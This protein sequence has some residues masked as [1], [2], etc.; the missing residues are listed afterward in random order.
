MNR[1]W[2]LNWNIANKASS[3]AYWTPQASRSGRPFLI[4][5]YSVWEDWVLGCFSARD[6]SMRSKQD[7]ETY[8]RLPT[9]AQ[10]SLME[11]GAPRKN[12]NRRVAPLNREIKLDPA[13]GRQ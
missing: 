5:P 2:P 9:L 4:V 1:K 12:G 8:L 6:R 3:S 10:I 13:T 11:R 7:I